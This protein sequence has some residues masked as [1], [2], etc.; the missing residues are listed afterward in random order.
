[1]KGNVA[2]ILEGLNSYRESYINEAMS[3]N[4]SIKRIK[5]IFGKITKRREIWITDDNKDDMDFT[6]IPTKWISINSTDNE[7]N[8]EGLE[9]LLTTKR[10]IDLD[11]LLLYVYRATHEHY[12][13]EL[14]SNMRIILQSD[15]K[16]V[17]RIEIRY[18]KLI[19]N[20]GNGIDDNEEI[21][22]NEVTDKAKSGKEGAVKDKPASLTKEQIIEANS[23]ADGFREEDRSQIQGKIDFVKKG[24]STNPK[25]LVKEPIKIE[26]I[27][28]EGGVEREV[29][30]KISAI[31]ESIYEKSARLEPDITR[32]VIE[33]VS[34]LGGTM[35][36]L[37][38]RLKQG[39]SLG[40]KIADDS[41]KE[42]NGDINKAARNVKDSIRFTAIFDVEIFTNGYK[43]AKARLESLGYVEERCKNFYK[44]YAEGKS[45]QKAIQ[46]V[47]SKD[48]LRFE[49][50]FHTPESQG[51][52]EINHPLYEKLRS[53]DTSDLEKVILGRRMYNLG[54]NIPDP[55]GVFSIA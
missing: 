8:S 36:G 15:K 53:A 13:I 1:M 51:V 6:L 42:Y 44:M 45:Q 5:N 16:K 52:K 24:L 3:F 34:S 9:E 23:I 32:D 7:F 22:S 30:E 27:M 33:V 11:R 54:R 43:D 55:V 17:R 46:C 28:R 25:K 14:K 19:Y 38:F 2:S 47:Y 49:L 41:V 29:A 50:Q 31:A 4:S 26:A 18:N 10:E 40:R 21:D 35:Y 48:G 20:K 37:D 39:T 12:H